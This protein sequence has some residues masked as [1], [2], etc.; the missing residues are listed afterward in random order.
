MRFLFERKNSRP[1]VSEWEIRII[2]TDKKT[3]ENEKMVERWAVFSLIKNIKMSFESQFNY[4]AHSSFWDKLLTLKRNIRLHASSI[5]WETNIKWKRKHTMGEGKAR[6]RRSC[7]LLA[8][9]KS[10][11][12]FHTYF[13]ALLYFLTNS[14]TCKHAEIKYVQHGDIQ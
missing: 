8:R 1:V 13:E 10:K 5:S 12:L 3:E 9:Q 14:S 11:K 4:S 7:F 6:L 2:F